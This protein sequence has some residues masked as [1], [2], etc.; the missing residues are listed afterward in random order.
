MDVS[1]FHEMGPASGV[2]R[3]IGSKANTHNINHER[4]GKYHE[5]HP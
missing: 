5:E 1:L 4:G 2:K 3:E